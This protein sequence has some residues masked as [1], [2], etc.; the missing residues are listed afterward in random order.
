MKTAFDV[1]E[2]IAQR[3]DEDGLAYAIGG[4]L[5]LTAL[6]IPRDTKDVD[7]SI[8]VPERDL[9]RAIDA[10]ERAGVMVDRAD[11][12]RSVARIAMFTGRHGRTIV[13]VF[14]S[15]HPHTRAMQQRRVQFAA[16]SGSRLWFLS[17]EDLA[18]LKLL[19]ARA[20]DIGDLER[21][22]AAHPGLDLT[23]VRSWLSAIVPSGDRR[24][25]ILDDLARRF[26]TDRTT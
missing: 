20:K 16:P 3:L 19:Y 4:A 15:E 23:Y 5:A 6:A 13:D 7:L 18:V 17:A 22:F 25:A 9:D 1:A 24:L 12:A 11:A 26:L 2:H 10:L 8:F 14:I 21:L